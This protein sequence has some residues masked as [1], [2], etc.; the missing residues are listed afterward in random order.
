MSP[1]RAGP[2]AGGSGLKRNGSNGHSPPKANGSTSP[3]KQVS[4]AFDSDS[5]DDNWDDELGLPKPPIRVNGHD[6]APRHQN[7]N[8][9]AQ[10]GPAP[11]VQAVEEP[12]P[13]SP[14]DAALATVLSI[15]PDVQP[16]H[17]RSLLRQA[18]YDGKAELVLENILSDPLYPKIEKVAGGKG[19]KRA[20]EEEEDDAQEPAI[21][22]LDIK[23]QPPNGDYGFAA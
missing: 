20:R 18:L 16:E 14:E 2:V 12:P 23:R 6:P 21:N 7:A 3:K 8:G 1:N 22:Y 5:D 15:V 19:K 9:N 17:V 13:L 11:K 10:A 4:W